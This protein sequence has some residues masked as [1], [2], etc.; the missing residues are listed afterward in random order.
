[1]GEAGLGEEEGEGSGTQEAEPLPGE[2]EEELVQRP[3]LGG[4]EF[5]PG[6]ESPHHPLLQP[7]T[8]GAGGELP[9][10]PLRTHPVEEV[11][12]VGEEEGEGT[13]GEPGEQL[14]AVPV[15]D[16]PRKEGVRESTLRG[17]PVSGGGF[18]RWRAGARKGRRS[19]LSQVGGSRSRTRRRERQ[20]GQLQVMW[21]LFSW[22]LGGGNQE[23]KSGK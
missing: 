15:E 10:I 13:V 18:H 7:V 8:A 5:H 11:G 22:R 20:E 23:V 4:R 12:R 19:F 6:G 3:S 1:M 16:P 21:A 14:P 2:G 9:V 17:I